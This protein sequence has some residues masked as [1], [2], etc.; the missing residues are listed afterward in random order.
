[1]TIV[2][3][4]SG[5][6]G[7]LMRVELSDGSFF[8]FKPCYL[9]PVF[10]DESLYTPGICEGREISDEEADG[11]R[12]AFYCL[13]AEKNALRLIARAEQTFA[14]L[15]RKLDMRGHEPA[16]VRQ[17]VSRL[18]EMALLDDRRFVRLWLAARLNRRADSPRRLLSSLRARGID[19]EDAEAGLN[20]AL[21]IDTEYRLLTRYVKKIQKLK[22]FR[23]IAGQTDPARA[24]KFMLKGEGFSSRT[25]EMFCEQNS[26]EGDF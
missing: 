12:F 6:S 22:S 9:P 11:F 17:V 7:E 19:R 1:M 23:K 5:T 3:I 18:E 8:S 13:R 14:G 2:S 4:K 25:I 24:L 21:D 10:V 26:A 20:A 16:C 15:S